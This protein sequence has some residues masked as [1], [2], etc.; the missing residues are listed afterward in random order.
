MQQVGSSLGVALLNT[1]A[2]S[3]TTSYAKSHGGTTSA[4]LVHGFTTAFAV[5]AG[6]LIV[7][8]IVVTT[9]IRARAG[10]P[11]QPQRQEH[12]DALSVMAPELALS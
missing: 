12:E 7:A 6:L 4:A 11:Q 5:S 3:A 1:I 8:L 2:T 10:G 9:L